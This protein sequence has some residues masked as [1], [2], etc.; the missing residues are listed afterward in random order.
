LFWLRMIEI[1]VNQENGFFKEIIEGLDADESFRIICNDGIF[2][3]TK[4]EFHE[5]FDNVIAT[6]SYK[7]RGHYHSPK[8]PRKAKKKR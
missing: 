7:E 5:V 4:N 8:P 2:Q 1:K 6:R 3:M